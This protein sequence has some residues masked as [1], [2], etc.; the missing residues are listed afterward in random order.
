MIAQSLRPP[1]YTFRAMRSSLVL[2][3]WRSRLDASRPPTPTAARLHQAGCPSR[4]RRTADATE[5]S[6]KSK[7]VHPEQS[8]GWD[9]TNAR[10]KSIVFPT[11]AQRRACPEPVEPDLLFGQSAL[12][13]DR[14]PYTNLPVHPTQFDTL[15]IEGGAQS[16]RRRPH[17]VEASTTKKPISPLSG[18]S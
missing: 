17:P 10:T 7:G 13:S 16:H 2:R 1:P 4:A 3:F 5:R 15:E 18:R 11:E 9:T 8:E 6:R 12:P 14:P